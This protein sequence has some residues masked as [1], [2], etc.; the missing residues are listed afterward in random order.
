[1][2]VPFEWDWSTESG[3]LDVITGSMFSGKTRL[4]IDRLRA[5]ESAGHR[6]I[7]LKH[8]IDV[9]YAVDALVT[10][11]GVQYPATCLTQ[12]CEI[13]NVSRNA[14]ILAVE[15]AHFWDDR[16]AEVVDRVRESGKFVIVVGLELDAA[17]QPFPQVAALTALADN[18]TRLFAP[19]SVCDAPARYSQRMVKNYDAHYVGGA[20]AYQ[21]RCD[22]HFEPLIPPA[23]EA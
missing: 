1:M 3:R 17:G 22:K 23:A 19:C 21:P 13:E 11:D 2:D 7:A 20:G 5:G 4:L 18:V 9:R 10:H 12:A 6:V 8:A 16:L 14:D 15:E